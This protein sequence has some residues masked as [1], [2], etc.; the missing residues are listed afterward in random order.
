M[1]IRKYD[2]GAGNKVD[3]LFVASR[4]LGQEPYKFV[5]NTKFKDEYWV[6]D[7]HSVCRAESR[8]IPL[9]FCR[10]GVNLGEGEQSQNLSGTLPPSSRAIDF[11]GRLPS[12]DSL[13]NW[14]F[15]SDDPIVYLHGKGG[16]GK[17][18]IAHEFAS[19]VKRFGD[20]ILVG[21]QSKL[22]FVIYLSAKETTFVPINEKA[23]TP[24]TIDFYDDV[25]LLRNILTYSGFYHS[26]DRLEGKTREELQT[27]TREL[28]TEFTALIVLDDIDTLTTKGIDVGTNFLYRAIVRSSR[29][30]RILC[31]QRNIATHAINTSIEVPGLSPN[32]EYQEFVRECCFH[33]Q[34]KEPSDREMT[35]LS[36]VS[37]RRPLIVEYAIVL[38]RSCP[39]FEAVFRLIE[40]NVGDDIRDYVFRR[41][42][43]S[44]PHGQ[45][46]R[47]FLS[48][49]AIFNR[50]VTAPDLLAVLQFGEARLKDAVSA[51]RAMFLQVNDTGPETTYDLDILT[52]NFVNNESDKA[53]YGTL[54]KARIRNFEKTYFP[55][56][57]QISRLTMRVGDLLKRS[58]R[59]HD[60]AY[61]A[62][63]WSI[64]SD[65]RLLPGVTEH[66]Q[67]KSVFG[68]VAARLQP[69]RLDDA[70]AAFKS[71]MTTK[72]EPSCE[73]LRGWFEAERSSG[74]GFANCLVISDFVLS[75]RNYSR[76]EK[77]EFL[78]LKAS[79]QFFRARDL[80]FENVEDALRLLT[81][82]LINNLSVH[83]A[84]IET[85]SYYQS[86][87]EK[88]CRNTSFTLFD[89]A[90]RNTGFDATLKILQ[91]VLSAEGAIFDPIE[92]PLR[93][94]L[95]RKPLAGLSL[96]EIGRTRSVIKQI[97]EIQFDPGSWI[98]PN[99]SGRVQGYIGA[100]DGPLSKA[101]ERLRT[102]ERGRKTA[103]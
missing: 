86:V 69:P 62:D 38:R 99:G 66:P 40:S 54:L 88:N 78:S 12:M 3:V 73:H 7:G 56:I 11:V 9:L 72:Y 47:S 42:W 46:A 89:T 67:F 43:A 58:G 36:L 1:E 100:L 32:G 37:E 65:P 91:E 61:S 102:G 71:V 28:L 63:A 24:I 30:S 8:H 10:T 33:Y 101:A 2:L 57:P 15:T 92:E 45:D 16:S 48:A 39:S 53:D 17:T 84:N 75:G 64:V 25:S 49:I 35:Q 79:M 6:R 93:I 80:L 55:D 70:R 74:I 31:T 68:Y 97:L 59:T 19:V 52:K 21:G 34:V 83:R 27:L 81:S 23:S 103:P 18:T 41:E 87:S 50:P 14:L 77:T 20:E 85:N 95:D 44:L 82:S 13:F 94:S 29:A 5:K 4:R 22:D 96:S 60:P 51:T 98:D 76:Q 26:D 90:A